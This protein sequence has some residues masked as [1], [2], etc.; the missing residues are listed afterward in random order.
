[1]NQAAYFFR[2]DISNSN[3][4]RQIMQLSLSNIGDWRYIEM[5]NDFLEKLEYIQDTFGIKSAIR[6]QK[7]NITL[8]RTLRKGGRYGLF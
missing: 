7:L 5:E 6:V 2:R 3:V 4:Y 8:S 1:M